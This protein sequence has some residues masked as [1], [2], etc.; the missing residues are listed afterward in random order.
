MRISD[1][2]SDVCS[3]DLLDRRDERDHRPGG[4]VRNE[5]RKEMQLVAP[6]TD[7]QNDREGQHRQHAGNGEVVV[8]RQGMKT[9]QRKGTHPQIVAKQMKNTD[10]KTVRA[11]LPH[12]RP[13]AGAHHNKE[14]T[15]DGK[16]EGKEQRW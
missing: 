16:S 6:E 10:R 12:F 5:Q 4:A 3:S 13:N 14:T 11:V 9:A 8:D 2:S 7:D 1:W 15:E